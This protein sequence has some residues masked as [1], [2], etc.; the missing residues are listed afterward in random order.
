M[1]GPGEADSTRHLA[2]ALVAE[3]E[4]GL[5][6]EQRGGTARRGHS[7]PPHERGG[8]PSRRLSIRGT[9]TRQGGV[10]DRGRR[11]IRASTGPSGAAW[12]SSAVG[13]IV[14]TGTPRS[15]MVD[16][17]PKCT[18]RRLTDDGSASAGRL[19]LDAG[20]PVTATARDPGRGR[21]GPSGDGSATRPTGSRRARH[22]PLAASRDLCSR[23]SDGWAV[24]AVNDRH[25]T[26]RTLEM[27]RTHS[28]LDAG[29]STIG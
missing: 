3:P 28:C 19:V 5:G 6:P 13:D 14:R 12:A 27:A 7:V 22:L 2:P 11:P 20:T 1:P 8:T 26:R 16:T 9:G 15:T 23:G 10:T 29:G 24:S 4:A 18:R 17:R 21:T 25:R